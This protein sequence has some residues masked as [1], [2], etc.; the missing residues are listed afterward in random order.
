MNASGLAHR[1]PSDGSRA[2][3]C[4]G[5]SLFE[6]P[7]TDRVTWDSAEVT[8]AG[9]TASP[10]APSDPTPRNTT[11]PETNEHLAAAW[12]RGDG[13]GYYF[14]CPTCHFYKNGALGPCRNT[15]CSDT[16]VKV[17]IRVTTSEGADDA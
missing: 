3:P 13:T 14:D 1:L 9:T 5:R 4:C 7:R 8:C 17:E 2:Y 16:V 15:S 10:A 11:M 12:M 6:V